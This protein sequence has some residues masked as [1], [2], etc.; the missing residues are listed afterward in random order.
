MV[1]ISVIIPIYNTAQYLVTCLDSVIAQSQKDLEI[2][3]VNNGSTDNSL[4]ILEKYARNDSRIK[5]I[6]RIHGEVA[7][8]RNDALALAT[9]KFIA[10]CDSDD[11]LPKNAYELLLHKA[12]QTDAD[13][14][15]GSYYNM[16][17]YGKQ[18]LCLLPVKGTLDI[19]ELFFSTPCVWNKLF[20]RSF[21]ESHQL[22]FPE[23]IMGEDVLFLAKVL[24]SNPRVTHIMMPVYFY[25]HHT[26]ADVPS[27]THR[28]SLEFFK[29]HLL[30]RQSLLAEMKNT[31]FQH[32][33]EEYVYWSMIF[34]L[35]DFLLQIWD[36]EERK[37]AFHIFREHVLTFDWSDQ[38]KRFECIFGMG[39]A[40][41][42][43]CTPETYYIALVE[44]DPR[45]TVLQEYRAG[46]I[47]FRYIL[48][49][50]KAWIQYKVSNKGGR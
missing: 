1:K 26:M 34:F 28:Y 2:I 39:I 21:L 35:R 10:F 11:S 50:T 25:W 3:V 4:E 43:T 12:E 41:F 20:R 8:A 30:C 47:G 36:G 5:I 29:L 14:V 31:E 33:C 48:R 49:Y 19:F 7:N 37:A 22:R 44:R 32:R 24:K 23:L 38:E 6:P 27:M 18:E 16:D 46:L 13:I 45:E 9:G 17:D 15:A 42:R 40:R